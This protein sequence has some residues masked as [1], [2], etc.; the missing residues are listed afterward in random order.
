[1]TPAQTSYTMTMLAEHERKIKILLGRR[2]LPGGGSGDGSPYEV[3][4]TAVTISGQDTATYT[5]SSAVNAIA[6][7]RN[8]LPDTDYTFSGGTWTFANPL[9]A[10]EK[11]IFIYNRLYQA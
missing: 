10:D 1:M 6:V 4:S 2:S 3:R 9:T 11:L 8:N 5:I 7:V